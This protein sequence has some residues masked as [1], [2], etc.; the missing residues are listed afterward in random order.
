MK[1][2]SL[3][4]IVSAIVIVGYMFYLFIGMSSTYPS[5]REYDLAI[6]KIDFENKIAERVKTDQGWSFE[7]TDSVEDD[8]D[9]TCYWASL[10]YLEDGRQLMYDIKYCVRSR[11]LDEEEKCLE[12]YVVGAFD[13]AKKSGGYK[14]SDEDVEEL[15]K[16]LDRAIAGLASG[17]SKK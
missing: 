5:I 14:S 3:I 12:L 7:K 1:V 17:C 4:L 15:M 2:G 9:E 10:S 6:S 13:Y 11:S 8:K 16:I